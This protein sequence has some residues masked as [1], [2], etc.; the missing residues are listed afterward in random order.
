MW[1]PVSYPLPCIFNG[2]MIESGQSATAYQSNSVSYGAQCV[3]Q[4]RACTNGTLSGTYTNPTCA[5]E[6][7]PITLT[8]REQQSNDV[9]DGWPAMNAIDGNVS[10]AYSSNAFTTD[11]NDRGAYLAAWVGDGPRTVSRVV[12][13]PRMVSGA[14]TAFPREYL[15]LLTDPGNTD[16]ISVGNFSQQPVNGVATIDL[17]QSYSTWGVKIQPTT[18]ATDPNGRYYFQLAEMGL[19]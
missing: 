5:I 2:Q 6:A 18:L 10:T 15:I 14:P 3:S 7:P 13:T 17:N 9:H 11:Q 19:R 1:K 16:R 8:A 4:Q 12:L